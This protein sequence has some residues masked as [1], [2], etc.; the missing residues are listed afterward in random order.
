AG[1]ARAAALRA[2]NVHFVRGEPARIDHVALSQ[3]PDEFDGALLLYRGLLRLEPHESDE[4]PLPE[5]L[6]RGRALADA[7][8]AVRLTLDVGDPAA[9]EHVAFACDDALAVAR[10]C[11][12]LRVSDN[13]YDDLAARGA[14]A[15]TRVEELR[16]HGVLYDR[17]DGGGE[18]LHLFT[19]VAGGV[20]FEFVERRGGYDGYGAVNAAV[21]RRAQR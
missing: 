2:E 8:R 10:R 1:A 4:L 11:S 19:D 15:R 21:R 7:A 9:L 16:A 18:L 17:D 14:L 13:Y 3:P 20:F 12:P 6:V 5:A